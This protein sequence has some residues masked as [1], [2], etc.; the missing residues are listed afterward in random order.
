MRTPQSIRHQTPLLQNYTRIVLEVTRHTH[1][2]IYRGLIII[3]IIRA[4]IFGNRPRAT[5]KVAT[6]TA[7]APE[8]LLVAHLPERT[9]RE[10][11]L[12]AHS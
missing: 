12:S 5:N 3:I 9:L 4:F 8:T 10:L 11:C 6:D 1:V 7:A 2:I